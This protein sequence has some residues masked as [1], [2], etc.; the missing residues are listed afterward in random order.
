MTCM[1]ET[2]KP[3]AFIVGMDDMKHESS[4]IFK[5]VVLIVAVWAQRG[6]L[7]NGH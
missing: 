6:R 2:S 3:A 4:L 7:G 1:S 5:A